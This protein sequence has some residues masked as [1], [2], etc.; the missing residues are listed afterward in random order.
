MFKIGTVV[1]SYPEGHSVDVLLNNGDRL[2]NVQVLCPTGSD[3]SGVIDLPDVGGP[4]PLDDGRWSPTVTRTRYVKAVVGFADGVP[5]VQ[6]FLLPQV[7]QIT[8][9]EKN[10]RI[11]RHASDWYT[12]VDDSANF[13]AHHPSGT[14]VRIGTSAAH[15][16]LSG[17]DYD[18]KWAIA[19]NTDKQVNL[20]VTVAHGGTVKASL[21][22]D[23]A[24]N[25]TLTHAGDLTVHTDGNITATCGGDVSV[26]ATGDASLTTGGGIN[27]N[28]T[29]TMVFTGPLAHFQCPVTIDDLLTFSGGIVGS[30]TGGGAAGTITGSINVVSGDVTADGHTLKSHHH[31]GVQSGSSNTLGPTG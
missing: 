28:A 21:N 29:G 3:T 20:Q 23:P 19:R 8:F 22:I 9:Q 24:G 14:F 18:K 4:A 5:F 25:V 15:E 27:V 26:D 30:G 12:T 13:E 16:D 2:S 1:A 17:K 7:N 11:E 6:G 10:R 31:G